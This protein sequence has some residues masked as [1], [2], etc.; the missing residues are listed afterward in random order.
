MKNSVQNAAALPMVK[1][2]STTVTE[3][4]FYHNNFKYKSTSN[5]YLKAS[6]LIFAFLLL[7]M[8]SGIAD[9]SAQIQGGKILI[10][11]GPIN[12]FTLKTVNQTGENLCDF[13]LKFNGNVKVTSVSVNGKDIKGVGKENNKEHV[14]IDPCVANKAPVNI[15]ATFSGPATNVILI[16]TDSMHSDLLSNESVNPNAGDPTQKTVKTTVPGGTQSPT[17]AASQFPSLGFTNLTGT[18]ICDLRIET[19]TPIDQVFVNNAKVDSTFV[20]GKKVADGT[21]ANS[22]VVHVFIPCIKDGNDY[23]VT[24]K[25]KQPKPPLPPVEITTFKITPTDSMHADLMSNENVNLGGVP[26]GD[27]AEPT[28]TAGG[29]QTPKFSPSGFPRLPFVNE[30]GTDIC[31]MEI[32]VPDGTKIDSVMVNDK[33]VDSITVGSGTTKTKPPVNSS[34]IHIYFKCI[35]KDANYTVSV[36]F[37][38]KTTTT[39]YNYLPTDSLHGDLICGIQNIHPGDKPSRKITFPPKT[40]GG[41]TP[42]SSNRPSTVFVNDTKKDICDLEITCDES[43]DSIKVNG[44]KWDTKPAGGK[45][46]TMH[47]YAPDGGCIAPGQSLVVT[48]YL[49]KGKKITGYTITFTSSKNKQIF[50]A[51]FTGGANTFNLPN[52]NAPFGPS[53]RSG[54][55]KAINESCDSIRQLNF[56]SPNPGIYLDSLWSPQ[57]FSFDNSTQVCTFIN[58]I[59][60]GAVF[61]IDFDV[62][63]LLP[64]SPTDTFPYTTILMNVPGVSTPF[65]GEAVITPAT[66]AT[67]PNGSIDFSITAGIGPFNYL[68]SNGNT[69]E[70]LSNVTSGTYTLTVSN[71]L[72]CFTRS[73]A[74]PFHTQITTVP[75]FEIVPINSW[76]TGSNTGSAIVQKTGIE[77]AAY[78]WS[79]GATTGIIDNLPPGT[80]TCTVTGLNNLIWTGTVT[81]TEPT[82]VSPTGTITKLNCYNDMTGAINVNTT[83]GTPFYKYLWNGGKTTQNRTGL[84]AANYTVTVT[85]GNGCSATASFKVKQ[86][87]VLSLTTTAID[88]QCGGGN[89]G[90]A[91]ATATGGTQPATFNWSNGMNGYAISGLTAGL[92]NVNATDAHGCIATGSVLV[93]QP[94]PLMVNIFPM[95]SGQAM[96]QVN[97]GVP[98]YLYTWN[99]VPVQTTAIATGLLP[100]HAYMVMVQDMHNCA[101]ATTFFMPL[102]KFGNG[103]NEMDVTVFPNPTTGKVMVN[104]TNI[105][106]DNYQVVLTDITGRMVYQSNESAQQLQLDLSKYEDGIYS[107]KLSSNTKVSVIKIVLQKD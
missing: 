77:P 95:G 43:I 32:I 5:Y 106:A 75:T 91:F 20:N 66:A 55:L 99:T 6:K 48:I 53:S 104:L 100:N 8:I 4:G 38:G 36:K 16:P 68:W 34:T 74:I 80:F 82:P 86:P 44:V 47:V 105:G 98:P 12:K 59:A 89:N 19:T 92:Y 39:T 87:A 22:N 42:A 88:V 1:A 102:T 14:I 3:E 46:K 11:A 69:N 35:A 51:S 33:A 15:V 76:C 17:F 9:V 52:E 40:T 61:E 45:G 84:K 79:N 90:S 107:L 81:I 94:P 7:I 103:Y 63:V 72:T 101:K 31:D 71:G 24:V 73:F 18:D 62:N 13:W 83:G 26:N 37:M 97:G 64:Y 27:H 25:L 93:N 60:P 56:S 57:P 10:D 29:T 67:A 28:N 54:N 50:V 30:T 96:A 65:D 70:D 58:P 21:S 23:K 41:T 49:P 85:D 2:S 78:L